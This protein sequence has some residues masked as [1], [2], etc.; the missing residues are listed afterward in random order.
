MQFSEKG[1]HPV[2]TS[3]ADESVIAKVCATVQHIAQPEGCYQANASGSLQV[4]TV[5]GSAML[6]RAGERNKVPGNGLR[7]QPHRSSR[8]EPALT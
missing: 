8:A 7:P 6:E 1:P 4:T 5:S 2:S 3:A